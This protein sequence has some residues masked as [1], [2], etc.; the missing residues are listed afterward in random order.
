MGIA[1]ALA[2]HAHQPVGNFDGVVEEAYQAAYRP[3]LE[4]AARRPWLRLNLHVSGYLLDWLAQRHPESIEL[5]RGL[6]NA[7]RLELLGGGYY[8]PILAVIPAQHQQLQLERLSGRMEELLGVRPRGAWLAERVWEPQ[9]AS[10]LARAGLDYTI[11]D[12]HHFQLAG[13]PAGDI[14]GY[15]R[16]E[17]AGSS[18]AAVPSN[19]FL[20]LALPFRPVQ[21][22][23][24]AMLR[25]GREHP[26]SLLTMGDDLE[27]FGAWPQT[28]RHVYGDGWL[29][30]FFDALETQADCIESVLLSDYLERHAARGLLYLPTASYPEMMGWA[31]S[32]SWRGF[33][34]RYPEANLLHKTVWDLHRRHQA[35]GVASGE[36][37]L[38]AECN[39]VY[40]HGW[41]GGLYS[42]HLRNLAFTHLLA[43][44]A[45]LARTVAP[46][47]LRRFDLHGDGGEV[48]E[49]RSAQLRVLLTPGAGGCIEELDALVANANLVNS[50]QRT[51]EPYHED[52][53]ARVGTNPAQLPG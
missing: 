16:T 39:D 53:R 45:A 2:L 49:M 11:L 19:Y 26:G 4:A 28:A 37:L 5:L 1:F 15:W 43:A 52:L 17:D 29:E 35:A 41:F 27:K 21:E 9:I 34:T 48:V 6:L 50:M 13:V 10:V 36:E 24:E 20:R 31:R 23:I 18:L 46:L 42:P 47:P 30:R 40:W 25:A 44:D 12:D 33:L 32:S 14:H 38:A 7:Q 51:P 8:E 3:F 22:G